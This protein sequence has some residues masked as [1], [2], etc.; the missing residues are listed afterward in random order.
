MAEKRFHFVFNHND[1]QARSTLN[2]VD[3]IIV[4]VSKA[5]K[6][7][8]CIYLKNKGLKAANVTV[9]PSCEPPDAL[10]LARK[11][12]VVGL[13]IDPCQ[14]VRVRWNSLITLGQV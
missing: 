4:G 3:V 6:T 14:L 2:N 9:I 8:T 11:P 10:M 13:T 5:S 12:L 7:S 1:G